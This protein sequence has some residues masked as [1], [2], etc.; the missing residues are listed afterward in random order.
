MSVLTSLEA[1]FS[2]NSN[3]NLG[4][5]TSAGKSNQCNWVCT[6]GVQAVRLGI[7]RVMSIGRL[8]TPYGS[9]VLSMSQHWRRPFHFTTK[10]RPELGD[11]LVVRP[12][13]NFS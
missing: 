2:I 8:S 9:R 5:A 10:A 12:K 13:D 11:Q 1:I 3:F 6:Q 7:L 4:V